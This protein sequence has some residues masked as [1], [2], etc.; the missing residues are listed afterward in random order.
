MTE[1]EQDHGRLDGGVEVC[2]TLLLCPVLQEGRAADGIDLSSPPP[3]AQSRCRGQFPA[4]TI[5]DHAGDCACGAIG[6]GRSVLDAERFIRDFLNRDGITA[7]EVVW[8]WGSRR[9]ERTD[10]K[11][12]DL[13][14]FERMN[15]GRDLTYGA[16][17]AVTL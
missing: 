9:P 17:Y 1:L 2:W 11:R 14:I 8:Y 12:L 6:D 16:W 13:G 10:V 4:F 5:V 7:V 3:T 15:E